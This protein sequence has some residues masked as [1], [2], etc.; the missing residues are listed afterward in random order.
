MSASVVFLIFLTAYGN[1]GFFPLLAWI[2]N[3]ID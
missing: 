3:V 1:G 2:V